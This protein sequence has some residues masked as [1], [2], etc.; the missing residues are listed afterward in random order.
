M[1]L[2]ESIS[3]LLFFFSSFFFQQPHLLSTRFILIK[4]YNSIDVQS[5]RKKN[6]K[7]TNHLKTFIRVHLQPN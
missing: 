4:V 6:D 2:C 3:F 5:R 7:A 1:K